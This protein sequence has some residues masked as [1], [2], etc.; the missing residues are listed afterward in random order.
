MAWIP[1]QVDL[2]LKEFSF[3]ASSSSDP[4]LDGHAGFYRLYR[5]DAASRSHASPRRYE[6]HDTGEHDEIEPYA[7]L[8]LIPPLRCGRA[9]RV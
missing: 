4:D 3:D 6:P 9:T 2:V 7:F 5:H 1:Q 8:T